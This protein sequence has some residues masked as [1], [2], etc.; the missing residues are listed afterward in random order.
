MIENPYTI[1]GLEIGASLDE[2][3]KAFRKLS[4]KHHPDNGGDPNMFDKVNK[5]WVAIESGKFN[6]ADYVIKR[7]GLRH[8]TLFTFV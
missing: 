7:S 6:V 1:L 2:C 5:A 8:K 3:K 4:R